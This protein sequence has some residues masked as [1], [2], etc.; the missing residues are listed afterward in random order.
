MTNLILPRRKFLVGAAALLAMPAIVRAE[1][2]MRVKTY[3]Q[4]D[5]YGIIIKFIGPTGEIYHFAAHDIVP[6]GVLYRS[7]RVI[8][9]VAHAS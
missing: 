8:T 1:N 3:S 9:G 2:I 6:G 5:H 7:S 4:E